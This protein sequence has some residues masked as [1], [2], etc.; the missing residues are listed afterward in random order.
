MRTRFRLSAVPAIF[1]LSTLATCALAGDLT[2]PGAP[3]PT[4]KPLSLVEPRTAIT[5][6]MIPMTISAPGSFYLAENLTCDSAPVAITLAS[7]Q[8]SID[9]NGFSISGL[10]ASPSNSLTAIKSSAESNRNQSVRGGSVVG[11]KDG[12]IRLGEAATIE[13]VSVTKTTAGRVLEVG[14]AG[15]VS[16]AQLFDLGGGT[17]EIYG[18]FGGSGTTVESCSIR[19]VA[20]PNTLAYGISATG[21]ITDCSVINL[22]LQGNGFIAGITNSG[23]TRGCVVQ[24]LSFSSGGG[25]IT[26][27]SAGNR[28]AVQQCRVS[29]LTGS[30]GT[31]STV[32]GI[33]GSTA[34][35]QGNSVH[36]ILV[37]SAGVGAYGIQTSLSS[38]IVDNHINNVRT[39]F[40][41]A[42]NC[43]AA[44]IFAN[45]GS[46][47]IEGNQIYDVGFQTG[48]NTVADG[49][50]V[51]GTSH[52]LYNTVGNM[53]GTSTSSMRVSVGGGYFVGNQLLNANAPIR[54]E[55]GAGTGGYL[56]ANIM[57]SA[58]VT[59]AGTPPTEGSVPAPNVIVP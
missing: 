32:I 10:G 41:A 39:N 1:A 49:I 37:N 35:I 30:F 11:F 36:N 46:H 45:G 4:M 33:G 5:Q 22:S 59:V 31:I 16:G 44:G 38:R 6:S 13:D 57:R 7:G 55:S 42:D 56:A 23:V 50:F 28:G 14:L 18:I 40:V 19:D 17:T 51:A 15:R 12:A 21:V 29:D 3:A 24:G 27:I 8:V 58:I 2:P 52:V 48:S 53:I 43:A 34:S 47:Y 54:F 9:L 25:S 26:G 20:G